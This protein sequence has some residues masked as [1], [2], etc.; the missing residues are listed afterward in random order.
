M[1]TNDIKTYSGEQ[2]VLSSGRLVFSSRSND[3]YFNSKRYI[4]ISAGD[5][6]TIDVGAVDSDNE[7][8][9][10]LVNAPKMQLGLER[11]G[12]VEPIVKGDE[13][14]TILSTLMQALADYSTMVAA[15]AP[16]PALANEPSKFLVGR[17]KDIKSQLENFKSTKSFTI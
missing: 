10:F 7:E 15:T 8:N 13:L 14:D 4:N 9:I 16:T 5:K 2:I 1:A 12:T 6:V 17:F 11:Y 3:I